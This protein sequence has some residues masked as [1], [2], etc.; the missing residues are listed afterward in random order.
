MSFKEII[1]NQRPIRLLRKAVSRGHL[2]QAYLFLGPEGIGKKL[3]ALTL[4]KALN[5]LEG[6]ED[7]CDRCLSCKRIEDS[8]HPDVSVMG[9]EG[10]FIRIETIR[11]LQRSLSFRPYEGKKRVCILDGADRMKAEGANALLKTLEEPPPDTL[12]ILVATQGD[13]LL[14]TIVSRC[15]QLKFTPLPVDRLAG[16]IRRRSSIGEG[17]AKTL[18]ELSQGSLGRA[19]ELLDHEVW[20]KRPKIIQDLIDLPRGDVN[21]AFTL[22]ESL[23]DFGEDFP[24]VS[25]VM[26]SWYRDL[27][28]CQIEDDPSRLINRDFY[29]EAR[30]RASRSSRWS[31]IRRIDA[32]NRTLKA[33]RANVNRLL[34]VENLVLQ[35]R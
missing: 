2:P 31:L 16:E 33:L 4:A 11:K 21:R 29:Q 15:Q 13:L 12:L 1:G 14:P 22:A 8:N 23:A 5:C 3:T 7:C 26:A 35:L 6:G 9:P 18:A 10:Q 34:A 25:L 32:I 30:E 27:L 28:V 20:Q 24:L 19:L 17:E